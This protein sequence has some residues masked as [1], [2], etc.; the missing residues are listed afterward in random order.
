MA[1]RILAAALVAAFAVE[2]LAELRY[3]GRNRRRLLAAGALE[4]GARDY[5]W[6]VVLH[7]SFLISCLAEVWLLSPRV[8]W[9]LA[10]FMGALLVAAQVLRFWSL[11][12]LGRR[13]T[14]RILVLPGEEVVASGPYRWIRHPNYLAVAIEI[15]A[16]PLLLGAWRTAVV[17]SL[18]NAWVLVRRVRSEERA[19]GALTDYH[20]HMK[21]RPR[22]VPWR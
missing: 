16:L 21:K 9:R 20:V 6:M 5:P 22:M 7:A 3:A 17:F 1:H 2:R 8:E 18:A 4:I 14:T 15:L 19:L 12:T 11:R 13:W 10:A